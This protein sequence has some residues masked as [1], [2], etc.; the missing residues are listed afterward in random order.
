MFWHIA[1]APLCTKLQCLVF[2]YEY[3]EYFRTA[4]PFIISVCKLTNLKPIPYE[5]RFNLGQDNIIII[6]LLLLH[7]GMPGQILTNLTVW[8]TRDVTGNMSRKMENRNTNLEQGG[9]RGGDSHHYQ[10][11]DTKAAVL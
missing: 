2:T 1:S 3:L 4:F 9:G 8:K 5:L 7:W 10:R 11:D 6:L